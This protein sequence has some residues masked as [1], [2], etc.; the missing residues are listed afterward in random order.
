MT[1]RQAATAHKEEVFKLLKKAALLGFRHIPP[2]RSKNRLPPALSLD[3]K[4]AEL[5]SHFLT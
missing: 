5:L 4:R 2:E 1:N 3:Y